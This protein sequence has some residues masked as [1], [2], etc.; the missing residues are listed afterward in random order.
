M[1]VNDQQNER[2]DEVN[3]ENVILFYGMAVVNHQK[4]GPSI[5]NRQQFANVFLRIMQEES[6]HGEVRVIYVLY[7]DH[8]LNVSTHEKQRT[9]ITVQYE[10]HNDTFLENLTLTRQDL[11]VYLGKHLAKRFTEE[12]IAFV[13]SF[14]TTTVMKIG[15][16]D[17]QLFKNNHEEADSLLILH[18]LDVGNQNPLPQLKVVSLDTDVFLL[19]IY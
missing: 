10:V 13:V 2:P 1:I 19:L 5:I 18:V 15:S 11:T 7:I 9:Y 3:T 16:I 8:S 12:Q 6:S 14:K 17:P 4:L